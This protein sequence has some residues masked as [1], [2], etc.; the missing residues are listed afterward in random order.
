MKKSSVLVGMLLAACLS[1]PAKTWTVDVSLNGFDPST[2]TIA[3]G[4]TVAWVASDDLGPYDIVSKNGLW[5]THTLYY[6]GD[7]FT[8]RFS[9]AGSYQYSD[10]LNYNYGV[11][12]VGT[13]VQP[14]TVTITS[15]AGGA[16]FT[17]PATFQITAVAYD[18]NPDG[19]K[20]V[21]FYVDSTEVDDVFSSPYQTTV[22]NIPAG[23]HYIEAIVNDND[24]TYASGEID[25][26]V[27]PALNLVPTVP[28]PDPGQF[29]FTVTGL[30]AG[31]QVAL[32]STTNAAAPGVTW[33]SVATNTAAGDSVSFTNSMAGPAGFFR[34]VLLQ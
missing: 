5:P 3:P 29:E 21:Q 14:P 19:V 27:N 12:N 9:T 30:T 4:D 11:V 10:D 17:A 13:P 6:A 2:V 32:Q 34:V 33:I 1:C 22:T 26:T 18:P 23:S 31:N 15:P 7:Y 16:V 20:D 28:S 8:F 24:G 25:F